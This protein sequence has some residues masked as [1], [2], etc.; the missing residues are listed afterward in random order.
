[1]TETVH[2]DYEVSSERP[3]CH[4]EIP[5]ARLFDVT[6]TPTNPAQVTGRILAVEVNGT[7]LSIDA[8]T[9]MA[10]IDFTPTAV[11]MQDVRTVLT[12]VGGANG[13]EA[14]WGTLS[15]GDPV[16]YDNSTTMVALGLYLSTSPNNDTPGGV[17]PRANTLFGRIVPASA[18]LG[19]LAT[20][21]TDAAR[22]PLAAGAA[23]NTW[24]V[25][26]M[27]VGAGG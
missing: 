1:M 6:P 12:Y 4:W 18:A 17:G 11:Y 21:D 5:Y 15:I 27:Q 9:A 24:R 8:G 26:V 3:V 20:W 10:V 25:A 13:A 22:F 19:G 2:S 16:Y 23:G 7:V 14:T